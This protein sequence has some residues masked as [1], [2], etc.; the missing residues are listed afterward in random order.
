MQ[1]MGHADFLGPHLDEQGTHPFLHARGAPVKKLPRP[2]GATSA[3]AGPFPLSYQLWPDSSN[4]ISKSVNPGFF[5]KM[6][7][8]HKTLLHVKRCVKSLRD[9]VASVSFL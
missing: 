8:Y 5:S 9:A 6:F 2:A 4:K 1:R 3:A 7:I